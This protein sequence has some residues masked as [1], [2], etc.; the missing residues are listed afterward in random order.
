MGARKNTFVR[1]FAPLE[2]ISS[3]QIAKTKLSYVEDYTKISR[4]RFRGSA[5]RDSGHL[6]SRL[7][8]GAS[9]HCH[10]APPAYC[11]GEDPTSLISTAALTPYQS[12][13]VRYHK[14]QIDSSYQWAHPSIKAP[15]SVHSNC[16]NQS[17]ITRF[18]ALRQYIPT[19]RV[20]HSVQIINMGLQPLQSAPHLTLSAEMN[21]PSSDGSPPEK[22]HHH[23]SG[24]GFQLEPAFQYHPQYLHTVGS[25]GPLRNEFGQGL[26]ESSDPWRQT[27]QP[28]AGSST[29][30]IDWVD[31]VG[32]MCNI[33]N[34]LILRC[35]YHII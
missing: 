32:D 8:R 9:M 1:N 12:L 30:Q 25:S 17:T 13:I 20:Q 2:R 6:L 26:N 33:G 7:M 4:R 5:R 28:I 27:N 18:H 31:K 35:I 19:L 34:R 11:M 15:L 24:H 16:N 14:S 21:A 22:S 23:S 29:G 3:H 10:P